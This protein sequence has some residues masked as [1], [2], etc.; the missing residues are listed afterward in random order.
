MRF[1]TWWRGSISRCSH[2]LPWSVRSTSLWWY[3]GK[4]LPSMKSFSVTLCAFGGTQ[5]H[6]CRKSRSRRAMSAENAL[7]RM[8]GTF[9]SSWQITDGHGRRKYSVCV[10]RSHRSSICSPKGYFLFIGSGHSCWHGILLLKTFDKRAVLIRRYLMS[11]TCTEKALPSVVSA[12][13]AAIAF[14]GRYGNLVNGHQF[15]VL[16]NTAAW[17]AN[18]FNN[19]RAATRWVV[20]QPCC[21]WFVAVPRG[22]L[23]QYTTADSDCGWKRQSDRRIPMQSLRVPRKCLCRRGHFFE[24]W[25]ILPFC[26]VPYWSWGVRRGIKSQR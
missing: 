15:V 16:S 3:Y 10:R 25:E 11:G 5:W 24:Q 9:S 2:R 8:R 4:L 26:Y 6:R 7:K 22:V 12:I 21:C 23:T 13:Y 20:W 18:L 1:Q 17:Q 14:R 19:S